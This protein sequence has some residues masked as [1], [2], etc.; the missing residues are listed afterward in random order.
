M[1]STVQA[2]DILAAIVASTRRG[3]SVRSN[4]VPLAEMERRAATVEP[5]HGAF[6]AALV[7]AGHINIIAEC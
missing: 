7:K 1:T 3:V 6:R 2:P 4:D 5:R